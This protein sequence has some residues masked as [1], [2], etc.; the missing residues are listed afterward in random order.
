[1]NVSRTVLKPAM[2]NGFSCALRGP[3]VPTKVR[4]MMEFLA[5]EFERSPPLFGRAGLA[6][7]RAASVAGPRHWAELSSTIRGNEMYLDGGRVDRFAR[8]IL[9]LTFALA[10]GGR[11]A[12]AADTLHF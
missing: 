8:A 12:P 10:L 7:G 3:L 1:M 4:V 2:S 5:A 11:T 9:T 6:P